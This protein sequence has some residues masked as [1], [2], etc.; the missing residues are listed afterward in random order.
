MVDTVFNL[1][2]ILRIVSSLSNSPLTNEKK[3]ICK[4]ISL[5]KI[6]QSAIIPHANFDIL[7]YIHFDVTGSRASK[8]KTAIKK[9]YD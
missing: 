9:Q 7:V 1:S 3:T 8:K 2:Q 4:V 5:E 6:H